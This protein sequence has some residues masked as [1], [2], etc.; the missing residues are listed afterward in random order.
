MDQECG[1]KEMQRRYRSEYAEQIRKQD[2]ER[3]EERKQYRENTLKTKAEAQELLCKHKVSSEI[4][5]IR[6]W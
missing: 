4:W 1:Q 6:V 3:N 2:T 5:L